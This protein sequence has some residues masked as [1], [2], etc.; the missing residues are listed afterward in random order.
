MMKAI[1]W[2]ASVALGSALT[3]SALAIPQGWSSDVDKALAEAKEKK[4]SVLLEF[5]GSDWCP[6]CIMMEKKVFSQPDF[7]KKASEN[8]V[9]VMLDFPKSGASK[10]NEAHATKY[11]IDSFPTVVILNSDGKEKTRFGASTYPSV[12]KFLAHLDTVKK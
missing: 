9:L 12:D 3:S 8:F 6:P 11:K 2:L 7:V 10:A 1:T 5:T 4:K